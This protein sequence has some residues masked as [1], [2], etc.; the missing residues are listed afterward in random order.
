MARVLII[1]SVA[2]AG[3]LGTV[4]GCASDPESGYAFASSY[5][6]DVGTIAVPVFENATYAHGL[7]ALVTD[8]VIKEIHRSTPW[9]V[10]PEDRADTVLRAVITD[11]DFRSLRKNPDSGLVQELAY[12]ITV[13]FEWQDARTGRSLVSR[14]NF[15]SSETFVPAVGAQERL[16]DAQ[17]AS[18]QQ[19]ARDV[20]AS[21]R[22]SW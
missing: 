7:E 20:V 5:R 21:L 15:R 19:V 22:S 2:S 18:A 13:S 6:E 10:T 4:P 12:T 14:K 3:V 11:A 17:A 9:R 16:E 1:L 8:A